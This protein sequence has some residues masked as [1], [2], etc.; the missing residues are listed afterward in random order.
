MISKLD[1]HIHTIYSGHSDKD[2]TVSNIIKKSEDIGLERIAITEHAF[3]W[4]MG[5]KGNLSLIRE[6]LE[7]ISTHLQVDVGLEI[8]P[9]TENPGELHF[10]DFEKGEIYPV[11]VGFHGYPGVNKGW[12][13]KLNFTRRE[14]NRIYSKWLKIMHKLIENPKVDILAHPGR[15]IMQNGIVEEFSGRVLRDFYGIA[16]AAKQ[17]NVAFE[18]NE[19]LLNNISTKKLQDSYDKIIQVMVDR[20]V[21]LSIGSDAHKLVDIGRFNKV[22]ELTK[23]FN[24]SKFLLTNNKG[25][26]NEKERKFHTHRIARRDRD[27]SNPRQY[28][29][30]SVK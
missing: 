25:D 11:L 4:H 6:E 12:F 17:Y 23:S 1:N 18:L 24:L 3:D 13:E 30:A 5:P 16:E 7:Q 15:I 9:D 27:H 26:Q 21:K 14:K 28:A 29:V 8:D 19:T 22:A 20:K 10:N 2:M